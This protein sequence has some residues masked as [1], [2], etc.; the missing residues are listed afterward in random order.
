MMVR[1]RYGSQAGGLVG[2]PVLKTFLALPRGL[3]NDFTNG[4]L[5]KSLL[6]LL[7]SS[8]CSVPNRWAIWGMTL[9]LYGFQGLSPAFLPGRGAVLRNSMSHW[10]KN[11]VDVKQGLHEAVC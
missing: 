5:T 2:R 8:L 9:S 4:P 6:E 3:E 1:K 7:G 10:L 11:R